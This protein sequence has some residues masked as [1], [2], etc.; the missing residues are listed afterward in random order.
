V[1]LAGARVRDLRFDV[2]GFFPWIH[3]VWLAQ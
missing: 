3:E 2:T 1:S